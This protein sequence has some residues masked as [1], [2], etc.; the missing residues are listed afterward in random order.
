MSVILGLEFRN[1]L[2]PF[3]AAEFD[4]IVA[5]LQAQL[6]AAQGVGQVVQTILTATLT[7]STGSYVDTGLSVSITP[8]TVNNK[9]LVNI[10]ANGINYGTAAANGADFQLLRNGA[11]LTPITISAGNTP[12]GQGCMAFQY[13]DSPASVLPLTYAVQ[14]RVHTSGHGT[15]AINSQSGCQSSI[16][17]QEFG[18]VF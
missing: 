8:R 7:D 11:V 10:C 18:G 15:V 6:N 12:D 9:I 16:T 4:Q 2:P 17:V 5:A 3:V 13:L 14:F 1:Q